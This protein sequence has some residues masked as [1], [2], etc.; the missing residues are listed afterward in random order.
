VLARTRHCSPQEL[1]APAWRALDVAVARDCFRLTP[2][3]SVVHVPSI[4][5]AHS[6]ASSALASLSGAGIRLANVS[7]ALPLHLS[8]RDAWHEH[9]EQEHARFLALASEGC[10]HRRLPASMPR[11]AHASQPS[12]AAGRGSRS[13]PSGTTG[14]P[15][16]QSAAA[17]VEFRGSRSLPTRATRTRRGSYAS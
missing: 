13:R 5:A 10:E 4:N 3:R 7:G 6:A 17:C 2:W 15:S 11:T 8:G 9:E 14:R 1:I 16:T 12:R